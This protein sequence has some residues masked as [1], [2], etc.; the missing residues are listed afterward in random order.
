MMEKAFYA[1]SPLVHFFDAVLSLIVIFRGTIYIF[2][3]FLE[4]NLDFTLH[5]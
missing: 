2:F 3:F 4:I 1:V 5:L